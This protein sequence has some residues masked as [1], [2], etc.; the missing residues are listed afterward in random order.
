MPQE[1]YTKYTYNIHT[2]NF[3]LLS[4]TKT[5]N[6]FNRS[7]AYI[8]INV[9]VCVCYRFSATVMIE[10]CVCLCMYVFVYCKNVEM[11][12]ANI[13]EIIQLCRKE[14]TH[15]WHWYTNIHIWSVVFAQKRQTKCVC[16][17]QFSSSYSLKTIYNRDC[18]KSTANGLAERADSQTQ[19]QTHTRNARSI[20]HNQPYSTKCVSIWRQYTHTHVH[21]IPL[22]FVWIC[23]CWSLKFLAAKRTYKR[24]ECLFCALLWLFSITYLVVVRLFQFI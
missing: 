17:R 7:V 1:L 15:W 10:L 13:T 6:R 4:A 3:F 2:V 21:S 9:F 8:F 23:Q 20:L 18:L 24:S 11:W 16:D 22:Y 14:A 5:F 19:T 12:L